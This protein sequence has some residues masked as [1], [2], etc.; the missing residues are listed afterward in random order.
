MPA[1]TSFQPTRLQAL[2]QDGANVARW[3]A[4][5]DSYFTYCPS[6]PS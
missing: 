5:K 4:Y 6:N 1:R 2:L 3:L